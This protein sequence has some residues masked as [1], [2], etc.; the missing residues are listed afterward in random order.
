MK[1]AITGKGGVGKST[2]SSALALLLTEK[3]NKVLA[4]DADPDANLAAALGMPREMQDK[5]IPIS[6]QTELIEERTGAKVNQYGQMFK[7]NPE[8]SDISDTYATL[9]RGISLLVLGA[10][11]RGGGG[12][13]C[14]ENVL[15][16]ALVRDL[17]LHKDETLL[18]DMEAGIEHLGRATAGGVD[19]MLVVVEPGQMSIECAR[20]IF[21]L[22]GEIGLLRV[23][24]VGNKIKEQ[25]DR[26]FIKKALPDAKILGFISFREEFRKAD[27]PGVSI[28]D[29]LTEGS[30]EEFNQ[31]LTE[32]SKITSKN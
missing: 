10:I 15:L 12:C 7:L 19:I 5:I 14:P 4:I 11:R 31:I 23:Y 24:V 9:Y 29:A 18:L 8:V 13:A 28:L 27:R 26:E 3:G 1:I 25:D 20:K 21:E 2:I 16:R 32:I 6:K 17:I 30:L 22:S